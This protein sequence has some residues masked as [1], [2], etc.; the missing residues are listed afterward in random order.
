[1]TGE[2]NGRCGRAASL[3]V[4]PPTIVV[5]ISLLLL[6]LRCGGC[7]ERYVPLA[8]SHVCCVISGGAT[9]LCTLPVPLDGLVG[10]IRLVDDGVAASLT[11]AD[12]DG[13]TS[14]PLASPNHQ[15]PP[16]P[17]QPQAFA[18][19][20]FLRDGDNSGG[21]G[22]SSQVDGSGVVIF[23]DMRTRGRAPPLFF[24][25]SRHILVPFS[26]LCAP[27]CCCCDQAPFCLSLQIAAAGSIYSPVPIPAP[28]TI[29]PSPITP[30]LH[31][32]HEQPSGA[33]ERAQWRRR[34]RRRAWRISARA[35]CRCSGTPSRTTRRCVRKLAFV[36]MYV[37]VCVWD[38]GRGRGRVPVP[39]VD[40]RRWCRV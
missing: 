21:S 10:S 19:D 37:C 24:V 30:P 13:L 23:R 36:V 8:P 16:P 1:M 28:P 15:P 39:D 32:T 7:Q 11:A 18:F 27:C 12:D 6:L 4:M 26:S 35:R 22:S 3:V 9:C 5:V 29:P 17:P 38:G 25:W 14:H 2:W 34:S 40:V 31:P 20:A 33:E